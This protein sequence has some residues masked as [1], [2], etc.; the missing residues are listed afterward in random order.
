MQHP[1]T[2]EAQG[3]VGTANTLTAAMCNLTGNNPVAVCSDP[4]ITGITSRFK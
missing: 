3:A 2:P 1:S 4:G